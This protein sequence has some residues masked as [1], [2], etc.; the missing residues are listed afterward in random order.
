MYWLPILR[1][2]K[3]ALAALDAGLIG[4][5]RWIATA[6]F[7]SLFL[8]VG[9][10]APGRFSA[11]EAC[12]SA[13]GPD[14]FT[15]ARRDIAFIIDRSR[16]IAGRGQT[17]NIEIEGVI[18]ALADPTIIPRDGSTAVSVITFSE[19]GEVMVPLTVIDSTGD[20]TAVIAAVSALT[21]PVI[22]P[23]TPPCPFGG[24]SYTGAI[25]TADT[26][27]TRNRRPGARR[28]LL[29]SS[30]GEPEDPDLGVGAA[31]L[32]REAAAT[33]GIPFELNMI[34]VGL[35]T[36]S[37]TFAINRANVN[38]IV[39]PLPTGTLPG[40]TLAIDAGDCNL[41]GAAAGGADCGRQADEFAELTRMVLT[42]DVT[43]AALV[44]TVSADTALGT[45]VGT[46]GLSLRQAIESA[47]CRGGKTAITF[48][49]G[50]DEIHPLIPLPALTAPEITIDGC[51]DADCTTGVTID[52]TD[53]D[54]S[55]GEAHSDGILI[56]S[57]RNVIRGLNVK[58]FPRAGIAVDPICPF[59][60][61][62]RNRIE[63]N[64]LENNQ[65]AGVLIA[66]P[67]AAAEAG[68]N[69]RNMISRNA[70]SGSAT[71]IDLA[72]DGP[73][74]NDAGDADGGPN[75]LLNFPVDMTV[76]ATG[77]TVTVT[78]TAAA[79]AKCEIFGATGS[80]VVSGALVLTGVV[81]LAEATAAEDGTFTAMEVAP[82]PTGIYTATAT[83]AAGN[84]SEVL[85]DSGDGTGPAR[86]VA[87]TPPTRPFGDVPKD[88]TSPDRPVD[89]DNPGKA[90]LIITSCSIVKCNREDRDDTAMFSLSG[91]PMGPINPG[92]SFTI[93]VRFTPRICGPARAC[94]RLT[95]NDPER[96]VI[97]IELTGTGVGPA[98]ARLALEGGAQSLE[99]GPISATPKSRR[100]KKRPSHTFTIENLG[101]SNLTISPSS[102]LRTGSDVASGGIS[103][104]DDRALYSLTLVNADG[105]E[106]S[107]TIGGAGVI[108]RPGE[109]STFRVRFNPVIP[110]VAAANRGLSA[111]QAIPDLITSTLSLTQNAG[112]PLTINLIG[113]VRTGLRLINAA[114]PRN[115]PVI[116]FT[117]QDVDFAVD[118]SVYDAIPE[119]VVRARYE[120]LDSAGNVVGE[121]FD[122]DLTQAI[123]ERN[124]VR[125]QSFTVT[126]R[127]EGTR[128]SL[129]FVRVR[130][131][132][133]GSSSSD[134][135]ESR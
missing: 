38:L 48:A 68:T 127:F 29:M 77:T 120:F 12:T 126:Q 112:N 64:T 65:V 26:H 16:S 35:D 15:P 102:I 122:I 123:R 56:R 62:G 133:I 23:L 117:R 86:P 50:I 46:A 72:G 91:C 8:L 28:I 134:T 116:G 36:D 17:Y 59:D 52:G 45:P 58:N 95:T 69:T 96:P 34:L 81:F 83:D 42:S 88:T 105:T 57:A 27:L 14:C 94:L 25:M 109:R 100:P 90:P 60:T 111:N 37:E 55:E 67:A 53:T 66:D 73:T 21:C 40:A 13:K 129:K 43:P 6:A 9:I 93:N 5:R 2:N 7:I 128:L 130:V 92:E 84:T 132:V 82:S 80:E 87:T 119:D 118:F 107:L 49:P 115:A 10:A 78:G 113:R 22:G 54:V 124:L 3:M 97:L 98:L 31:T 103:N 1:R 104:A 131:T 51:K 33:L 39:F 4:R 19:A 41:P 70:I 74:P 75:T 101:C 18:R 121:T 99:F 20:A 110:A 85:F 114:D 44:V 106:T 24:T 71:L 135:G 63:L 47:N 11:D 79:G 125:G 76:V 30:D 89:G 108:I 61:V 32:A